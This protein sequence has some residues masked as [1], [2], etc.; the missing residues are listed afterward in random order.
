M[1]QYLL[2]KQAQ[3]YLGVYYTEDDDDQQDFTKAVSYFKAAA[4]QNVCGIFFLLNQY[5]KRVL[6]SY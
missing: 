4:D 5:H 2:V 6:S 1:Y 3:T